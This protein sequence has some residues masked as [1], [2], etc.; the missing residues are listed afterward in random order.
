M[1]AGRAP[2][3][4]H[5][6]ASSRHFPRLPKAFLATP[7]TAVSSAF[8]PPGHAAPPST[9]SVLPLQCAPSVLGRSLCSYGEQIFSQAGSPSPGESPL[10]FRPPNQQRFP[11]PILRLKKKKKIQFQPSP[12]SPRPVPPSNSRSQSG[13]RSGSSRRAGVL[14]PRFFPWTQLQ[15]W[16]FG[17]PGEFSRR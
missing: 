11:K 1:E 9:R 17:N 8:Q 2:P 6:S 7:G 14:Q 5:D 13:L 12:V 16:L 10:F 15:P 3:Y 4:S